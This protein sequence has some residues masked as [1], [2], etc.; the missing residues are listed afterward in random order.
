VAKLD[1]GTRR[2]NQF[3]LRRLAAA[4]GLAPEALRD[5][6]SGADGVASPGGTGGSTAASSS[7]PAWTAHSQPR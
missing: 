1:A 4:L 2:A 7:S 3:L 6:L 5:A